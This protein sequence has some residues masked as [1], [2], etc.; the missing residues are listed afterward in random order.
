[1]NFS[2]NWHT[3]SRDLIYQA[4]RCLQ[5][6]DA[7]CEKACPVHIPIPRFI[8]MLKSGN[9]S[10]A[11][12]E[13]KAANTLANICGRICPEEVFC[14]AVCIRTG[15]DE[16]V[17]IRE[18]HDF[19][20]HQE[21]VRGFRR[22]V[23]SGIRAGKNQVAIIGAGAAGLSCAFELRKLGIRAVL[24]DL[25]AE[26]GGIPA[27]V[28]PRWRMDQQ[29]V[30]RDL[31]FLCRYVGKPL[32]VREPV[33]LREIQNRFRAIF[34]ATG[35]WLDRRL[36]IPGEAMPEVF[37]AIDY[38]SLARHNRTKISGFEKVVVIG[39]GNVSLDVA[40]TA[41]QLGAR[42]VTLTYRRSPLEMK[43]WKAEKQAAEGNGVQFAY[44]LQPVEILGIDNRVAGVRCQRTWMSDQ[45]DSSGRRIAV[46]DPSTRV[47]IPADAVVV[48]IGQDSAVQFDRPIVQNDNGVVRVDEN[49]M[50]SE[51]GIFA[52][53]DL[54]RGE[55]TVVQAV[56][57]GRQAAHSIFRY[58]TRK[59][60]AM[61]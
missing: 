41:K 58:L 19:A 45:L 28:I 17:A 57:D 24:F 36:E 59:I 47:E 35:L 52:G 55:G 51:P 43:T 40:T 10:G 4:S 11:A 15:V 53:G 50:T 26:S 13:I 48:S 54:V 60:H 33:S 61:P 30:S 3:I 56:A 9:V 42:D 49:Y 46:P 37:H 12:E 8:R 20:T 39:G 21:A 5:C 38:L 34:L 1:M 32:Q 22:P 29:S 7:P 14:Q 44:Q 18:L 2:E 6:F 25:L 16:P 23:L 27:H 31:R